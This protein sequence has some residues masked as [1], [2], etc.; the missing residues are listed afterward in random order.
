MSF[1]KPLISAVRRSCARDGLSLAASCRALS[2]GPSLPYDSV[3]SCPSPTCPCAA[4]PPMPDGLKIDGRSPLKGLISEYAEQVLVCSG[5]EAWPS[6][7]EDDNTGHNLAADLKARLGRGGRYSDVSTHLSNPL[8]FLP[9]PA[10]LLCF[11]FISL[12]RD[13]EMN[14][15]RGLTSHA[16]HSPFTTS[17]SSTP[18]F[19]AL[20]LSGPKAR[21]SRR[22][23]SLPSST[24]LF[25]HSPAP[26]A[27]MLSSGATCCR[28][29]CI[30]STIRC[31]SP[32]GTG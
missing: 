8:H 32:S 18:R 25:C 24:F 4:A 19:Q 7:I 11:S 13:A 14:T 3:P 29:S 2:S 21:V 12:A 16:R 31:L 30:R 27:W 22:T 6:R 17:L 10:A 20:S 15:Q 1:S 28:S 26:K 9:P 23:C 5:T